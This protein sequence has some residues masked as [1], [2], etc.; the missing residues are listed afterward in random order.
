MMRVRLTLL[1]RHLLVLACALGAGFPPAPAAAVSPL[2]GRHGGRGAAPSEAQ[3]P[4]FTIAPY[5]QDVRTDGIVVVW[6]TDVPATGIV[7]LDLPGRRTAFLSPPGLHH[8]VRLSGLRPG[9]R[10]RYV[11][12]IRKADKGGAAGREVA[13]PP[14]EF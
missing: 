14:A 10:Y 3:A 5:L 11:V 12:A 2:P 9:A 6:E 8:E 7:R 13:T 4:H 1:R